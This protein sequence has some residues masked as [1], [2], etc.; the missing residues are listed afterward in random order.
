MS[1]VREFISIASNLKLL[2]C[3]FVKDVLTEN[4]LKIFSEYFERSENQHNHQTRHAT[5]N[6]VKLNNVNTGTYGLN[7]VKHQSSLT[8]NDFQNKV[9]IDMYSEHD[10]KIKETLKKYFFNQYNQQ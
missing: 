9:N 7:S 3:L 2:N 5:R 4:S 10:T 8:W 6:C 1:V